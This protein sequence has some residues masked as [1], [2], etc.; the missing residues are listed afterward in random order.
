MQALA[1]QNT[2]GNLAQDLLLESVIFAAQPLLLLERLWPGSVY[3]LI[4]HR[5][6]Y[7][8]V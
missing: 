4:A 8:N 6:G 7:S 5:F 3:S 2:E 1:A